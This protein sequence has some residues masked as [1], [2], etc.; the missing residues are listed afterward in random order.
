MSKGVILI[1]LIGCGDKVPPN[2]T[3]NFDTM[4][5]WTRA[6]KS[7]DQHPPFLGYHARGTLHGTQYYSNA[8]WVRHRHIVPGR[9]GRV[10]RV[11]VD[12]H[13]HTLK[14]RFT[15]EV[16][17]GGRAVELVPAIAQLSGEFTMEF[18]AHLYEPWFGWGGSGTIK[19]VQFRYDPPAPGQKVHPA[20][21]T[22]SGDYEWEKRPTN[23]TEGKNFTVE[24]QSIGGSIPAFRPA[25]F[26]LTRKGN[27]LEDTALNKTVSPEG[28]KGIVE[29]VL[30][31]STSGNIGILT[32]WDKD[33]QVGRMYTVALLGGMLGMEFG[34]GSDFSGDV[35][36]KKPCPN[37]DAA[38]V[39]IE[40]GPGVSIGAKITTYEKLTIQLPTGERITFGGL[41]GGSKL[42]IK[43]KQAR[44]GFQFFGSL[45]GKLRL[46][47]TSGK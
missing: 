7:H 8:R 38:S 22:G 2:W 20:N 5:G 25:K 35:T 47:R 27:K 12:T 11:K 10:S 1:N 44:L 26:P 33:M 18:H 42:G 19:S 41:G 4:K 31:I 14:G 21:F 30:P 32:V 24:F 40:K 13:I 23:M 6:G 34:G 37:W 9:R 43:V 39:M 17:H 15:V 16:F 28:I 29:N 3:F 46:I 36:L 45:H